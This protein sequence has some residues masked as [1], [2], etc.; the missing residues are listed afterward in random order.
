MQLD[1][2]VQGNPGQHFAVG[3]MIAL[4]PYLPNA[5]IG[6]TPAFTDYL[7][8]VGHKPDSFPIK[9][10]AAVGKDEHCRQYFAVDV[11]LQ[12]PVGVI[13]G[14]HRSGGRVAFEVVQTLFGKPGFAESVVDDLEFGPR[15]PSDV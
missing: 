9:S 12:L 4:R 10:P 14:A 7:P 11:K 2:A 6:L 1:Q 15:Q 13:P 8:K 3:M 5:V